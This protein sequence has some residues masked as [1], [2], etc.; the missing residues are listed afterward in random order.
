[1]VQ[2]YLPE[3]EKS[4]SMN[5]LGRPAPTWMVG[6]TPRLTSRRIVATSRAAAV[7]SKR[8]GRA[9]TAGQIHIS[10]KAVGICELVVEALS[11][12]KKIRKTESQPP[13]YL[14]VVKTFASLL[15]SWHQILCDIYPF[16]LLSSLHLVFMSLSNLVAQR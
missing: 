11:H 7:A 10:N 2:S 12:I 1:M 6:D 4:G 9:D 14:L 13:L 15:R 5:V 16:L 8:Y 3:R